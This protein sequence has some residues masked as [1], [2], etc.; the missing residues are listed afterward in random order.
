MEK[1]RENH[2]KMEVYPLVVT[3]AAIENHHFDRS[4]LYKWSIF[5]SY[6]SVLEGQLVLPS[7]GQQMT[8]QDLV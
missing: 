6:V 4:I 1:P 5:H 2:G 3:E 8:S 7:L